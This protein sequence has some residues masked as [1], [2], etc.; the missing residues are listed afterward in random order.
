M[1]EFQHGRRIVDAALSAQIGE[2]PK[3]RGWNI[4]SETLFQLSGGT[5]FQVSGWVSRRRDLW[6]LALTQKP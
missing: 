6:I 5:L 4:F 2:T 1:G 3:L